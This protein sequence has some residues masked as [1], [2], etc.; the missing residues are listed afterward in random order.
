MELESV[1]ESGQGL[2]SVQPNSDDDNSRHVHIVRRI[3]NAPQIE[4][5][6]VCPGINYSASDS[7]SARSS[8]Q[9][10]EPPSESGYN[11]PCPAYKLCGGACRHVFHCWCFDYA[12]G[13]TCKHV[14]CVARKMGTWCPSRCF[15]NGSRRH[16]VQTEQPCF[17]ASDAADG[18]PVLNEDADQCTPA[19]GARDENADRLAEEILDSQLVKLQT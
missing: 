11:E 1:S 6:F 18:A 8:T 16:D 17:D 14:L 3:G 5:V 19:R 7:S 10:V 13:F 12:N 2:W 4:G 15:L 9:L